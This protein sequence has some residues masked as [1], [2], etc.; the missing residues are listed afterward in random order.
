MRKLYK[1]AKDKT[2]Y[3]YIFAKWLKNEERTEDSDLYK[4]MINKFIYLLKNFK[5]YD[6]YSDFIFFSLNDFNMDV[7]DNIA[8][9]DGEEID[10]YINEAVK[11]L[12]KLL[13]RYILKEEF[14]SFLFDS[15][16]NLEV[17]PLNIIED[18]IKEKGLDEFCK[19]ERIS[20]DDIDI[21]STMKYLDK[22]LPDYEFENIYD[23]L[24]ER[25][26]VEYIIRNY[27]QD[28]LD[29]FKQYLLKDVIE[30]R[31]KKYK[32]EQNIDNKQKYMNDVMNNGI[33]FSKLSKNRI[34]KRMYKD[35]R[36][37]K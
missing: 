4:Y 31:N 10:D 33:D 18:W 30:L 13:T 25:S 6:D 26:D 5:P 29:M 24:S 23:D 7:P 34:L 11:Q 2:D 20:K 21:D 15:M 14:Y 8:S 12:P 22:N 35:A 1:L 36:K 28:G 32:E 19:K 17:Y 37:M 3:S 16:E 9:Y 27:V